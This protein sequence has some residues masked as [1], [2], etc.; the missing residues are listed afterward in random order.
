M[1]QQSPACTATEKEEHREVKRSKQ[2]HRA[3]WS[4][5]KH[6]P[7]TE[8]KDLSTA[9]RPATNDQTADSAS[10]R[11]SRPESL[12]AALTTTESDANSMIDRGTAEQSDNRYSQTQHTSY[13]NHCEPADQQTNHTKQQH[14]RNALA[15]SHRTTNRKI[16]NT[17]TRLRRLSALWGGRPAEVSRGTQIQTKPFDSLLSARRDNCCSRR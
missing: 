15:R 1:S 4:A 7:T 10:R 3:Y 2:Q 8:T 16:Q 9:R 14:K 6:L 12:S 11:H 13:I 17:T 5:T